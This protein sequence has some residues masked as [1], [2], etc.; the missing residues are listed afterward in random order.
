MHAYVNFVFYFVLDEPCDL[1]YDFI[2]EVL[3]IG[4]K[5][6]DVRYG[7]AIVYVVVFVYVVV[8]DVAY[9][10]VDEGYVHVHVYV[11]LRCRCS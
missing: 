2:D 9:V 8:D 10:A 7:D 11:C 4:Y 6:G 3:N 5:I 1:G